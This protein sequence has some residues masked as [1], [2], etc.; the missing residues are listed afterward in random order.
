M[1][2]GVLDMT[3]KNFADTVIGEATGKAVADMAGQLNNRAG[4]LPSRTVSING[5][6]ADAAPD[7]TLIINVGSRGGVKAGDR[8]VVRRKIRDVR[9]P[10]SGKILR[11]VE[12]NVGEMVVTQVDEASA[13]GKFSGAGQ[14]KVGDT[15]KNQ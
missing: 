2:G 6:V 5:L 10:A 8:L 15:V 1:A 12:E 14:P 3:S 4:A 11:S 9:D 7:G 13:V